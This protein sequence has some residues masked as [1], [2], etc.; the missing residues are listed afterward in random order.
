MSLLSTHA[1]PDKQGVD[2]SVTVCVFLY[3][4]GFFCRKLLAASNFA[5]WFIGVQG[6]ESPIFMN[7]ALPEAQNQMNR[8][9]R[10]HLHDV[11]NDYPLAPEHMHAPFVKSHGI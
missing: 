6:R 4:Y 11:R 10:H 9:A 1:E 3:G 8:P 2:I 5:L 7:F